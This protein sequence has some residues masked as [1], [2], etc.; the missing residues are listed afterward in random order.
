[1]MLWKAVFKLRYEDVMAIDEF[2]LRRL[3][4]PNRH[5]MGHAGRI[6]IESPTRD[7]SFKTAEWLRH[8]NPMGKPLDYSVIGY[9]EQGKIIYVSYCK[10]CRENKGPHHEHS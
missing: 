10:K 2:L 6:V 5:Y 3:K 9:D 7:D 4:K 1:M 8:Q